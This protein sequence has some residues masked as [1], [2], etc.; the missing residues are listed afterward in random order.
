[1]NLRSPYDCWSRIPKTFRTIGGRTSGAFWDSGCGAASGSSR[2][3]RPAIT[4]LVSENVGR[5]VVN[6]TFARRA[7]VGDNGEP[8]S[9]NV[10]AFAPGAAK[11]IRVAFSRCPF[12]LAKV[13]RMSW[14]KAACKFQIPV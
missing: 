8:S 12:Q 14:R 1:M 6:G 2:D 5:L 13:S 9:N 3:S 11:K 7:S 10:A 4:R